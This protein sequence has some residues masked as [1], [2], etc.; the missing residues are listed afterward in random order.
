MPFSEATE[1]ERGKNLGNG[2]IF[3]PVFFGVKIEKNGVSLL[4]SFK[5]FSRRLRSLQRKEYRNGS[6]IG[7]TRFEKIVVHSESVMA[8]C[9]CGNIFRIRLNLSRGVCSNPENKIPQAKRLLRYCGL[10][11]LRLCIFRLGWRGGNNS[12]LP[13]IPNLQEF[14]MKTIPSL[15]V[16]QKLE[17][18]FYA[19]KRQKQNSISVSGHPDVF[20]SPW[21]LSYWQAITDAI[22]AQKRWKLAFVGLEQQVV[23]MNAA[24]VHALVVL[25]TEDVPTKVWIS[26]SQDSVPAILPA[27]GLTTTTGTRLP[28]DAQPAKFLSTIPFMKPAGSAVTG[29]HWKSIWG[30]LLDASREIKLVGSSAE[31]RIHLRLSTATAILTRVLNTGVKT[32]NLDDEDDSGD[33]YVPP[34]KSPKKPSLKPASSKVKPTSSKTIVKPSS[35][36]TTVPAPTSKP[37]S[38]MPPPAKP[39]SKLAMRRPQPKPSSSAAPSNQFRE[40]FAPVHDKGKAKEK[41]VEGARSP[42]GS[43]G[44]AKEKGKEKL[45]EEQGPL[46]TQRQ[47]IGVFRQWQQE[48]ALPYYE[49][50]HAAEQA[51]AAAHRKGQLAL[52]GELVVLEQRIEALMR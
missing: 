14:P 9:V 6:S 52:K 7:T 41:L 28:H 24:V 44:R 45:V 5:H 21:V 34:K 50:L 25:A 33:D 1:G 2:S 32:A 20:Y 19:A 22:K 38:S 39:S 29:A 48:D 51:R 23:L 43:P 30:Q 11:C 37:T 4:G 15:A 42:S 3:G 16:I 12:H 46:F 13:Y 8:S 36:R 40:G 47:A 10:H 31:A 26:C 27:F 18:T 49:R 35:T 17:D